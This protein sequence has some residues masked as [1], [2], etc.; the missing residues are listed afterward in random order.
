MKRVKYGSSNRKIKL[1]VKYSKLKTNKVKRKKKLNLNY[2]L[3][4]IIAIITICFCIRKIL[5]FKFIKKEKEKDHYFF[6][7]CAMGRMENRYARELVSYYLSIGTEKIVIADNNKPN[8]ERISD[9]LQDYISNKTVDILD[10]IG[11]V[12]DYAQ[13]DQ[14]MYQKYSN[15]CDWLG[16]FDFDEYLVMHD[17]TGKNLTVQEYITN[18]RFNKC[19]AVQFNWLVT[20]DNDLVYY[21]NRPSI[22]RFTKPNYNNR[23]NVYVKVLARGGL[24]KTI[25]QNYS[26]CH[27]PKKDV[28]TCN[29]LGKVL[30]NHG[31]RV[32]P[33][34]LKYAYLFHFVTRT[35]EEYY[36][37]S[38]RGFSGNKTFDYAER[39][40]TFF[41]N[42]KFTEEK[43][44]VFE[45][46]FNRTF[47]NFRPPVQ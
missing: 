3:F 19:E 41:R 11:Q 24:N 43:L 31:D 21:D 28:I 38:A 29:S 15:R 13:Y 16:F 7:L 8:T 32:D 22:E 1:K 47:P 30:N 36:M 42:N 25:F 46:L 18:E 40:R 45:K 10:I 35:A 9:V 26:S 14:I 17:D 33:P 34:E 44:K 6:C 39:V 12:Y 23:V 37:K 27:M 5:K 20:G 4:L 2:I